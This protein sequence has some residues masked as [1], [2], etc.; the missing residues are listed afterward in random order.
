[1][2]LVV[3]GDGLEPAAATLLLHA[4]F[5]SNSDEVIPA[6]RTMLKAHWANIRSTPGLP[7]LD[8]FSLCVGGIGKRRGE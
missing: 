5:D 2:L 1:M 8:P 6:W 4:L 3:S 7:R